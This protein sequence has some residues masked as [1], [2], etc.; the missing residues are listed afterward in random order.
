M[1]GWS[2]TT[3]SYCLASS[4]TDATPKSFSDLGSQP[5]RTAPPV[6]RMYSAA[7]ATMG[8]WPRSWSHDE[9]RS[10][11]ILE[12]RLRGEPGV[13]HDRRAGHRAGVGTQQKQN[14]GRY[15]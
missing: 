10:S 7:V 1:C 13:G 3:R 15:L 14:D 11:A 12:R 5:T 4:S 6:S 8:A 2:I 9:P